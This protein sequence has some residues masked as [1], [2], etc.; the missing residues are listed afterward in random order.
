MGLPQIIS[1]NTINVIPDQSA[2]GNPNTIGTTPF[3]LYTVPTGSKAILKT[4]LFRSTGFGAGTDMQAVA[5]GIILLDTTTQA[6][7]MENALSSPVILAAGQ[8][9]TLKGDSA[10]NNESAFFFI[11]FQELPA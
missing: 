8:T 10:S 11:T 7:A 3:V 2:S 1:R 6:T 4:F 9:V 5:N